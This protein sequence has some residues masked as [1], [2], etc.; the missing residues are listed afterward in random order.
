MFDFGSGDGL[1]A[2]WFATYGADVDG[3]ELDN[4]LYSIYRNIIKPFLTSFI[5]RFHAGEIADRT[6]TKEV[7]SILEKAS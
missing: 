5:R 7:I 1:A 6:L 2:H 4:F 3:A